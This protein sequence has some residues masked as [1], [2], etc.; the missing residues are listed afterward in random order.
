MYCV[1]LITFKSKCIL[2]LSRKMN[3]AKNLADN[4]HTHTHTEIETEGGMGGERG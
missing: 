1:L 4:R 3:S 2:K